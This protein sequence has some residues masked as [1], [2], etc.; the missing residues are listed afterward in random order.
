MA[1]GLSSWEYPTKNVRV[2]SD[3]VAVDLGAYTGDS[4]ASLTA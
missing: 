3:G 4:L 2:R 1:P